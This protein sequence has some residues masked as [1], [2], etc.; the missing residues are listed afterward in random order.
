MFNH[1]NQ[2]IIAY[3]KTRNKQDSIEKLKSILRYKQDIENKYSDKYVSK[4]S[5]FSNEIQV[6]L[7]LSI[8][9]EFET[10][11]IPSL[12]GI[13]DK[14]SPKTNSFSEIL[15][16]MEP[17][18]VN[19]LIVILSKGRRFSKEE[20][21]QLYAPENNKDFESFLQNN[22]ISFLGGGNS[23]NFKITPNDNSTP[24]VLKVENRMGMPKAPVVKLRDQS[25]KDNLTPILAE[26]QGTTNEMTRTILITEF[27]AG[28][29]LMAQNTLKK[30]KHIE[31]A[32]KLYDQMLSCLIGI[33]NDGCA[34]PDMKNT[35]W[36]VDE[37]D[38][39]MLADTKSLVFCDENDHINYNEIIIDTGGSFVRTQYMNPPEFY[40]MRDKLF[41]SDNVHAFMFGKNLYQYLTKCGN[42]VLGYIMDSSYI[43]FED[44]IF[45]TNPGKLL[46]SLIKDL[47]KEKPNDRISLQSAKSK[48]NEINTLI[49]QEELE[50][51][52]LKTELK[53]TINKYTNT[54][55]LWRK[56]PKRVE[57]A[58]ELLR[59]IED[60]TTEKELL[61][62]I[63]KARRDIIYKD[64]DNVGKGKALHRS[65]SS[66]YYK[67]LNQLE[68]KV[69]EYKNKHNGQSEDTKNKSEKKHTEAFRQAKGDLKTIKESG[70]KKAVEGEIDRS[71]KK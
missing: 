21:A 34:F 30:K 13:L 53:N 20:L 22:S 7:F 37:H 2:L 68:E 60:S 56:D 44:K 17:E 61:K 52:K 54:F 35:N 10:L 16:N 69:D 63:T 51:S 42:E 64:I 38:K 57:H 26:R 70:F 40:K 41:S 6:K 8:K 48:I 67:T 11:G 47:I 65:G 12:Y 33:G 19:K 58:T 18:K 66:R 24:Y 55:T 43:K 23:K 4:C 1:L 62:F 45:K 28:G 27:C 14:G 36:L 5:D 46:E 29:D 32:V 15:A 59:N 39:L 49:K 31:S 25:L 71:F 50:F 3:N 9:K